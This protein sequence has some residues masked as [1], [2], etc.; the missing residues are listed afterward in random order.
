MC[1]VNRS[2]QKP[3]YRDPKLCR[4]YLCGLCP[5]ELLTGSSH[6]VCQRE[7]N[8]QCRAQYQYDVRNDAGKSFESDHYN[9]LKAFLT[10][11]DQGSKGWNH[12][13]LNLHPQPETIQQLKKRVDEATQEWLL[14]MDAVDQLAGEKDKDAAVAAAQEEV[15]K[16]SEDKHKLEGELR[17]ALDKEGCLPPPLRLCEVCGTFIPHQ[18]P[19]S[20]QESKGHL[21]YAKIRETLKELS[22]RRAAR[23]QY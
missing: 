8:P 10:R 19:A 3:N 20:H 1:S 5:Y 16:K 11:R 17:A 9:S 13:I 18:M 7:H 23:A 6:G 4:D 14:K 12:R 22:D 21:A 15:Q 2:A